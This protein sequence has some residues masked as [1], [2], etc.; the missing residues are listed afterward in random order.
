M[1]RAFAKIA[2][3]PNVQAAQVR[4]GSR[5]AYRSAE[6]GKLETV[7]LSTY[8]TEFIGARDSFYQGTVGENGWPYVQHRGGPAGFL[9]VLDA[10]TIGYADF[11]GNRQYIS[12]GNL[13]GD[14][15]VSLFL[16]D[17][18]GQRR[19]KIWGRARLIDEDTEPALIARLESPDYRA[20]VER[21]VVIAV[22]AFD[23]N[24][25][26][27][28][29]PR[30]TE[31]E[32]E[33]LVGDR[34]Q[35]IDKSVPIPKDINEIGAGPLKL[36]VTGMRQLTPHVRAYE[37]RAPDWADLPPV[38][39]GAHIAVPV[40]LPDGS[41]VTRQY[42]L[43]THPQRRDAVE[44]A[45]L[46]EDMGRGASA[47]IHA[48]WQIGTRLAIDVPANQ[49]PLHEDGRHA[50]LIAGGIG[51]TPIKAMAQALKAQG[52]SFEL[53]YSGRTPPEM[54]YRDWLAIEF[55]RQLHL[56]FTRSKGGR[57]IDLQSIM[58]SAPADTL[59][60][61]CGPG[62]LIE[63]AKSAARELGIAADLLQ[64]ESFE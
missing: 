2:F 45:V 6:L 13:D 29:T 53:H 49:F 50:V 36:V 7:E 64:Y 63:A 23:W 38:T 58:R 25:P 41:V 34:L 9:K 31:R 17:Y 40:R 20:R 26:K 62:Q 5:E 60:Y 55:P 12:V 10:H 22:E 11:S 59:F 15:R 33:E 52:S 46:R 54:A 24:C 18:P 43:A 1:A 56:Y 39:A 14:N 3:T 19:L 48:S 16:M 42:S 8:E 32:V 51:I 28:I 21:G 30:F 4:M 37:L 27:Y 57:R 61:V 47:A 44:I 35:D